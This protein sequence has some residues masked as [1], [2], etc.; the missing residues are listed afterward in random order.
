LLAAWD[1]LV[2]DDGA[3]VTMSVSMC[4]GSYLLKFHF[5]DDSRSLPRCDLLI[6]AETAP[7]LE[8]LSASFGQDIFVE[9]SILQRFTKLRTLC[10]YFSRVRPERFPRLA[11]LR[12]LNVPGE[13]SHAESLLE[14]FI[15]SQQQ[16]E[17]LK[18]QSTWEIQGL[19][20]HCA[21]MPSLQHVSAV[22]DEQFWWSPLIYRLQDSSLQSLKLV[23]ED[24][25]AIPKGRFPFPLLQE[26]ELV[27]LA[28]ICASMRL[29]LTKDRDT[30]QLVF[31]VEHLDASLRS[32]DDVTALNAV[33]VKEAELTVNSVASFHL[34][35]QVQ[36]QVVRVEAPD[37][38]RKANLFITGA[39][40]RRLCLH[41]FYVRLSR[42]WEDAGLE[43]IHAPDGLVTGRKPRH[44]K[45]EY[46]EVE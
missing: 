45:V 3:L 1:E 25:S 37:P 33:S 24:C 17:T 30:D 21:S 28:P 8:S 7:N 38:V 46:D 2:L 42:G 23:V 16:L 27:A 18:F 11:A 14:C 4:V 13:G 29:M 43:V 35:C 39:K 26:A 31:V 12:K 5:D 44:V 32:E 15:A 19:I 22:F 10:V 20:D 9:N 6:L 41:D 34:C 40:A 36:A